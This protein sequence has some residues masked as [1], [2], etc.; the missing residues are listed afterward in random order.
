MARDQEPNSVVPWQST[1]NGGIFLQIQIYDRL[2]E[3]MPGAE[4]VQ[5]GL[6]ESWEI[7]DDGMTYTFNLR[8]AMFSDGTPATVEDVKSR[9]TG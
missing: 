8:D 3:Q 1:G 7:S 6:A 9:S 2:V 4:E 5:P